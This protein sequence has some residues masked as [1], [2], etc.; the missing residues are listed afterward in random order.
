LRVAPRVDLQVGYSGG[1]NRVGRQRSY[2]G[3]TGLSPLHPS[4]P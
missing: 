2:S 1:I 4:L 3:F